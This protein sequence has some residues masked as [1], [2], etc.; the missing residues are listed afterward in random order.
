MSIEFLVCVHFETLKGSWLM[1]INSSLEWRGWQ[2]GYK[3][4]SFC[5][6]DD[7]LLRQLKSFSILFK[8]LLLISQNNM[9]AIFQNIKEAT[10]YE[11]HREKNVA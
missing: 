2:I 7:S 8:F 11:N 1:E 6:T 3:N 4:M 9:P 10:N 5:L